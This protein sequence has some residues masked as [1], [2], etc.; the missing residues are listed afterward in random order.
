MFNG[1][2]FLNKDDQNLDGFLAGANI[3]GAALS[4]NE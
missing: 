1:L 2:S 3:A 4:S